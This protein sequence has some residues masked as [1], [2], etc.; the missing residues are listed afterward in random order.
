MKEIKIARLQDLYNNIIYKGLDDKLDYVRFNKDTPELIV[1]KGEDTNIWAIFINDE[2]SFT[3]DDGDAIRGY[4]AS[5][6]IIDDIEEYLIGGK[7]E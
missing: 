4:D 1:A 2:G 7:N 3:V 5:L 6:E